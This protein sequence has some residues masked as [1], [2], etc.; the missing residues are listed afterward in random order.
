MRIAIT[1]DG[2]NLQ[3]GAD[4]AAKAVTLFV[5]AII[6]THVYSNVGIRGSYDGGRGVTGFDT[7]GSEY[8]LGWVGPAAGSG[9]YSH[10]F[11]VHITD[12]A[13]AVRNRTIAALKKAGISPSLC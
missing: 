12:K 5:E 7:G 9:D 8:Y 2:F 13:E 10:R 6:S 11:Q 1:A 4:D 3:A